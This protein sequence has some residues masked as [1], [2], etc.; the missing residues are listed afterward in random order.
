MIKIIIFIV[1]VCLSL[2]SL[3][4]DSVYV[5]L[6]NFHVCSINVEIVILDV[7]A[8]LTPEFRV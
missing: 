6:L 1:L 5:E 7:I 2:Q 4:F 8:K 3:K